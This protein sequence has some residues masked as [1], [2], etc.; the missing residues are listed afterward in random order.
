MRKTSGLLFAAACLAGGQ[1]ILKPALANDAAGKTIQSHSKSAKKREASLF[2]WTAARGWNGLVVGKDTLKQAEAKLGKLSNIEEVSGHKCYNFKDAKVNIFVDDDTKIIN[3]IW[4]SGE[5]KEP[6]LMPRTAAEAKR[7]YGPL[8]KQG[9]SGEAGDI[10]VKP[11]IQ[12]LSDTTKSP[13]GIT[14]MEFSKAQK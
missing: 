2:P 3:K 11:G 7:L 13:E 5:L 4:V 10:Y 6:H 1:M 8:L 14:W 9:K 12:M